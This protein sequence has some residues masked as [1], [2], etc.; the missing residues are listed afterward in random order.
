MYNCITYTSNEILPNGIIV[1]YFN[2]YIFI[3]KLIR[4]IL[5]KSY[6]TFPL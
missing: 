4:F 2:L 5:S 3:L 6:T 1:S